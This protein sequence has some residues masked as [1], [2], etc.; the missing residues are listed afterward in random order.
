MKARTPSGSKGSDN[1][2]LYVVGALWLVSGI[3][4]LVFK[5]LPGLP[6]PDLGITLDLGLSLILIFS[7]ALAIVM[8]T[9]FSR[10]KI[11]V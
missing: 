6:L 2:V 1:G 8:G 10:K 9:E 7:S 11:L 4:F 3:L 5:G